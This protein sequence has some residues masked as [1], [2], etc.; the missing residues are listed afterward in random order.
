MLHI[1]AHYAGGMQYEQLRPDYFVID[2]MWQ[3]ALLS[4]GDYERAIKYTE[5]K[6]CDG[7]V[8]VGYKTNEMRRKEERGL[9]Q[10]HNLGR[11]KRQIKREKGTGKGKEKGKDTRQSSQIFRN[12][13]QPYVRQGGE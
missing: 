8:A 2:Y 10:R 1:G 4:R 7:L 11:E 12:Q 6:H 5:R 3:N 13:V 9:E